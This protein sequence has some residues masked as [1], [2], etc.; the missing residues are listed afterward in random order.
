MDSFSK[1][2]KYIL[3][4]ALL[5]SLCGFFFSLHAQPKGAFDIRNHSENDGRLVF[6]YYAPYPGMTKVKL[7]DAKGKLVWRGQYIDK[8][9]DNELRLRSETLMRGEAYVFQFEY[10]TDMVRVPVTLN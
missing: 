1:L 10:K 8:E 5:V 7:F 2:K 6:N 9:G 4:T 3:R